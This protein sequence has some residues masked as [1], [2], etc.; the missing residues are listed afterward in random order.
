MTDVGPD[1]RDRARR[2]NR[3]DESADSREAAD[4]ARERQL[5]VRER[6]LERWEAEIAARAAQLDLLDPEEE[7]H[8]ARARVQRA[9]ARE[10]RRNEAEARRDAAIERDIQRAQRPAPTDRQHPA[11][12]M[13]E[14]AFESLT[15]SLLANPAVDDALRTILR[16]AV[17]TVPDCAAASI[18]LAASGRLEPA[19]STSPWAAELD[20]AQLA[21]GCGPLPMAAEGG[22]VTTD[23]L[24]T[25]ARWPSFSDRA[26][27]NAAR[28][29]MSFGLLVYGTNAGVLT[30]YTDV[31]ARFGAAARRHGDLLAT[32]TAMAMG[33]TFERLTHE[34]QAEAWQHALASR[35]T[36][37]QAKGILMEQGAASAEEAFDVLREA[38]QRLNTKLRDLAEHLVT[39]RR[40]PDA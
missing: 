19:G 37:G 1:E 25:D 35:D 2:A 27:A 15:G 29:A 20:V 13:A 33:R 40:L 4:D 7:E 17:A 10:Q 6:V 11:P 18:A 32:L 5:D 38:S 22:V 3:R 23:D 8:R 39:H 21:A 14:E 26:A 12:E 30:L 16:T 31:G 34:A 28:G 9:E 24:A 36:I